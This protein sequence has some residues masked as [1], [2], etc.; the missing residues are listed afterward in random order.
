MSTSIILL[1]KSS[2]RA[3]PLYPREKPCQKSGFASHVPYRTLFKFRYADP[4]VM[5]YN[6]AVKRNLPL[7]QESLEM[8][9]KQS[10][11]FSFISCPKLSA[12]VLAF[13]IFT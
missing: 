2:H 13:Y 10:A 4:I 12:P 8:I 1:R 7:S 3:L 5:N 11:C 6:Q 9:G